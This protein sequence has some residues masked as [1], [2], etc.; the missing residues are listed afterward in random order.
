MRGIFS[1][2]GAMSSW[3]QSHK[4]DPPVNQVVDRRLE[5]LPVLAK[6]TTF[7]SNVST[8]V[9]QREVIQYA[10][11]SMCP[12]TKSKINVWCCET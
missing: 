5:Q 2:G 7:G 4:A 3:T 12:T 6:R 11:V 8:P 9:W 1:I 10:P